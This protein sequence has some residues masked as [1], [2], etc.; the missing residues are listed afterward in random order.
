ML[1][2]ALP[3]LPG[4]PRKSSWQAQHLWCQKL[5]DSAGHAPQKPAPLCLC[6]CLLSSALLGVH[7]LGTQKEAWKQESKFACYQILKN[8]YLSYGVDFP[9]PNANESGDPSRKMRSTFQRQL[10]HKISV[11]QWCPLLSS[12]LGKTLKGSQAC[13]G[14]DDEKMPGLWALPF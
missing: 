14:G 3:S 11:F 7:R 13:D 9:N 2:L 12:L 1:G 5:A 8:K 4:S 10:L 6:L